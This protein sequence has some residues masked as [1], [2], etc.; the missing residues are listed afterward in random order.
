MA[1]LGF[2]H[3]VTFDIQVKGRMRQ[4]LT[5]SRSRSQFCQLMCRY[6]V[7]CT[8]IRSLLEFREP[9]TLIPPGLINSVQGVTRDEH[10][11]LL[12]VVKEID[13]TGQ[14]VVVLWHS[15]TLSV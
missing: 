15:L 14:E 5:F 7:H 13:L 8:V 9:R 11:I 4:H 12:F 10:Q 2:D 3:S 1:A 6:C